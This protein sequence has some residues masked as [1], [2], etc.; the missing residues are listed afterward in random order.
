V[1]EFPVAEEKLTTESDCAT[2]YK[3][4]AVTLISGVP[5]AAVATTLL[6]VTVGFSKYQISAAWSFP[7]ST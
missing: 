2:P 1:V 4:M 6:V 7:L 3:D 5:L